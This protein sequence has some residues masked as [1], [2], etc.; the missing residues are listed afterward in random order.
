MGHRRSN[1]EGSI[2]QRKDGRW[3]A[4]VTIDHGRRRHFFGKT[5]KEAA[6]KLTAALKSLRDG[7][8]L[9]SDRISVARY[10]NDW[11]ASVKASVRPRTYE[12]YELNVRR[13]LP[14]IGRYKLTQMTSAHVQHC[15]TAL[16]ENSLSKRTVEQ[17]HTVLHNALRQAVR[18]GLVVRNVTDA[19]NVPR[20]VRQEMRT[21]NTDQAEILF[22]ST[23]KDRPAAL[24]RLL[25][26]TGLRLGEALGLKW[27]D[28]NL[29]TGRIS[30]QRALQRQVGAGL[31]F[32][33]PKTSRSRRTVHLSKGTTAALVEHRR[34]QL[35]ER[36]AAGPIWLDHGVVFCRPDGRPLDPSAVN[37]SLHDAL[38][39]AGLPQIRVHDLRHTAASLLLQ[40]GVHARVVQEMLG[41]TTVTLTLDTYSHVSPTMHR[42]A[43]NQMEVLFG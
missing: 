31:V 2:Y 36:L 12:A 43:A 33:E 5:R 29:E 13:L 42:E 38:G 7:L 14:H 8:P 9:P 39:R 16:L 41:H 6:K 37:K 23:V 18:L 1:G 22:A 27:E 21:L 20:P 3:V 24:W 15:Y 26:T 30:I 34:R 25:L 28:L 17:V 19:V 4:S 40:Q 35:E 10:L 32:V 11:L